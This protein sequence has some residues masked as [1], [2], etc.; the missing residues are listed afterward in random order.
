MTAHFH[1]QRFDWSFDS[2]CR[3]CLKTIA[4]ATDEADLAEPEQNHVC[5]HPESKSS[6]EQ[7]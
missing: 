1:W 2:I 7:H 3:S 4:N 5:L 6:D